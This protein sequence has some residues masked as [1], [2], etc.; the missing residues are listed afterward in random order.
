MSKA[1]GVLIDGEVTWHAPHAGG[2]DYDTLCLIDAN[3]PS[4]GH[5]GMVEPRRGQKITCMECKTIWKGVVALRLRE[6]DFKDHP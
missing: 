3:D 4:I 5:E 2:N 6:S 1:V